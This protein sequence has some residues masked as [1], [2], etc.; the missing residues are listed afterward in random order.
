MARI[1]IPARDPSRLGGI[2]SLEWLTW[3]ASPYSK[4][5]FWQIWG[6]N[7]RFWHCFRQEDWNRFVKKVAQRSHPGVLEYAILEKIYLR[8]RFKDGCVSSES[9]DEE[10]DGWSGAQKGNKQSLEWQAMGIRYAWVKTTKIF[11]LI[12]CLFESLLRAGIS[13]FIFTY[14]GTP[15]SYSQLYS[16]SMLQGP[17][18]SPRV[19]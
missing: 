19:S 15:S 2:I 9:E 6:I 18:W 10:S 11:K 5:A 13:Q 4:S 17:V 3:N 8:L 12:S 7:T 16:Q 14:F 1:G